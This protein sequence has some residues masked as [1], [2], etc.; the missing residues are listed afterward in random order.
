MRLFLPFVVTFALSFYRGHLHLIVRPLL[1]LGLSGL[2][3][4][5]Q[6]INSRFLHRHS[7]VVRYFTPQGVE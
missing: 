6:S 1:A 7:L 4:K 3:I 5:H 2:D